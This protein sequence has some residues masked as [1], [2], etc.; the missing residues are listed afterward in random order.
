MKILTYLSILFLFSLFSAQAS[1]VAIIDSG[2][3]IEH[4]DL[5]D[6]IWSNEGEIPGNA[7]D[8]EEDGYIDDLYGWNFIEN[9]YK[10]IDYSYLGTLTPDI[11]KYFEIQSKGFLGT[12]TPEEKKWARKKLK[13]KSFIKKLMVYGNFMHGTHVAGIAAKDAPNTQ[14]LTAKIIPTE[15]KLPFLNLNWGSKFN[16][17]EFLFKKALDLLASQQVKFLVSVGNYVDFHRVDIANGSFGTGY[18]QAK[19]IIEKLYILNNFGK[20]P[21]E[22]QLKKYTLYFLECLNTH[23]E[24]MVDAA[25]RT[26]FVFA[27]GNAGSNNDEYPTF[28]ANVDRPNVI[29]VAAVLKN[30]RLARFS[31]YG[32]ETVDVAAP[33]VA[34]TSTVPGNKHLA[35]SGTS[36]AAPF[37]SKVAALIK[38]TNSRLYPHQI[39]KI[40]LGTVDKKSFL[41]NKVKSEGIVNLK[42]AIKAATLSKTMKLD[43]AI[44]FARRQISNVRYYRSWAPAIDASEFVLPLPSLFR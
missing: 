19:M 36:Q 34:I 26:L 30:S 21:T 38:E 35:V 27:A 14:I 1:I 25:R 42:R 31:N 18:D 17:G 32:K 41:R 40:I 39:K 24:K 13:D 4:V 20:K 22:E 43:R 44:R 33:G 7:K 2:T 29:S 9:N 15:I 23:G 8:D 3:D 28:P 12:I 16:L 11:R 5:V 37:V 10:V 6:Q